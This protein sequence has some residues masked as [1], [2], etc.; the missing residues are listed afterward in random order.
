LSADHWSIY[1]LGGGWGHLTHAL[2]L[3]RR[4]ASRHRVSILTNSPYASL[5]PSGFLLPN[6]QIQVLTSTLNRDEVCEQVE[7]RL[8]QRDYDCLIV[9][10]FPRGLGGEL[11]PLLAELP[12]CILRVFIHRDITPAYVEAKAIA[13]FVAQTYPVVLVPGEGDCVPLAHLPQ[14]KH[15]APWLVC[16][17]DELPSPEHCSSILRISDRRNPVVL[18]CAAGQSSE[19]EMFGRLAYQLAQAFP[20]VTVR[21]LTP[22][23]PATCPPELWL[24]HY[25]A[26]DCLFI[27]DVVVGSAGY[28]TVAECEALGVPLVAIALERIYDRQALRLRR[29]GHALL[30]IPEVD[31]GCAAIATVQKL[32]NQQSSQVKRNRR[33]YRNGAMEAVTFIE[34]HLP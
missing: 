18:V 21:C 7:E 2:A 28:N 12:T 22:S 15:T 5:I 20:D 9:D 10:T 33:Q 30:G 32:L 14:A 4:A 29:Y 23:Q 25:P 34:S 6:L 8:M 24:F 13:P 19:L 16:N 27:A 17:G 26:L 31:S 3:G 11:V 1:A